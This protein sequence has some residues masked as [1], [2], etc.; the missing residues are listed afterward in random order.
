MNTGWQ[1]LK[2]SPPADSVSCTA[3]KKNVNAGIKA[4]FFYQIQLVKRLL[5]D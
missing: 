2:M 3:W 4:V 5:Q 1:S